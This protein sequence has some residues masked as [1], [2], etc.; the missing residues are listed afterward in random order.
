LPRDRAPDTPGWRVRVVPNKYP[1]FEHQEVVVNA[2]QH[3]R[4][5]AELELEQLELVAEAWRLRAEQRGRT[6]S[7]CSPGSTKATPPARACTPHI[8]N[9]SGSIRSRRSH[10]PSAGRA[11]RSANCS[12]SSLPTAR[13]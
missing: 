2:P 5:I 10:R 12:R 11:A 7:C 3:V 1:A 13:G 9:S 4:S 6:G 8:R